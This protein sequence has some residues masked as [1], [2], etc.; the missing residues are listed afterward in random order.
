VVCAER[1]SVS[2]KV[3][4]LGNWLT[5]DQVSWTEP[6]QHIK[7]ALRW[8]ES[9]LWGARGIFE[10]AKQERFLVFDCGGRP[11]SADSFPYHSHT[12]VAAPAPS[13]NLVLATSWTRFPSQPSTKT[14]PCSLSVN[15]RY[16]IP[17]TVGPG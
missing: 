2:G 11:D 3:S 7:I 8:E 15:A 10:K 1:V 13:S 14:Y 12:A 16:S 4:F 9:L 6:K 17:S 5:T